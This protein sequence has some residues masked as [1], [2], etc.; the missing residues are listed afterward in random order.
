MINKLR[1]DIE[2]AGGKLLGMPKGLVSSF[3][4]KSSSDALNLYF[5]LTKRYP[6]IDFFTR[7]RRLCVYGIVQ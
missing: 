5:R 6:D 2:K 4:F 7:G 1:Q 3:T